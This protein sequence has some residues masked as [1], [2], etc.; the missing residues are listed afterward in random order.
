M[1]TE[2]Q[3]S[4]INTSYERMNTDHWTTMDSKQM[5]GLNCKSQNLDLSLQEKNL[6]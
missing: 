4:Q 6:S 1:K 5:E 2:R 3:D